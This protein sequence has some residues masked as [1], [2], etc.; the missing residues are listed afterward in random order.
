[1]SV[2]IR[3]DAFAQ[4]QLDVSVNTAKLNT[5]FVDLFQTN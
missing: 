1:M 3:V 5:V 4:A 2:Q